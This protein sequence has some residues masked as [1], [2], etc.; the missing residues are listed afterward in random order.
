[1]KASGASCRRRSK[2]ENNRCCSGPLLCVFPERRRSPFR[3]FA[4]NRCFYSFFCCMR[5]GSPFRA[6]SL[7]RFIYS[8]FSHEGRGSPFRA[9]ERTKGRRDTNQRF[10]SR[11]LPGFHAARSPGGMLDLP[12]GLQCRPLA[13]RA[14][15]GPFESDLR[16]DGTG[17]RFAAVPPNRGCPPVCGCVVGIGLDFSA[18]ETLSAEPTSSGLRPPSPEGEGLACGPLQKA[19]PS[20]EAVTEGD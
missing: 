9:A 1:M 10:V 14:A 20:G 15:T 17:R 19:S 16:S 2:Q 5:H 13:A 11:T 8:F 12:T 4:L 6:F 3:A 18:R 7:N